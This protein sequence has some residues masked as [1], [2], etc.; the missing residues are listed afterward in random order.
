MNPNNPNPQ[1]ASGGQSSAHPAAEALPILAAPATGKEKTTIR[2]ELIPVA[3]WRINDLRFDFGSSF[4]LPDSK[5]EFVELDALRKDNPGC[6]LTIFG[7]ADPVSSDSF[8]KRLSDHRAESIFGILAHEPARWEKLYKAAGAGEG[9]GVAAIQHMLTAI[10]ENPGPVT[11]TMNPSTKAAV[12]SFQKKQDGLTPDGDPG[13]KTREKLFDAYMTFLWPTP[14]TSEDFL[15]RRADSGGKGDMQG[16]SEFNPA[17]VFSKTEEAELNKAENKSKRN[18]ENGANRRV[19]VLLFRKDSVVPAAKWPC[20]RAGEGTEGC[21]K[22]FWSDGDKRRG[23]QEKRR[24]FKDTRDTFACR[25]YHRLVDSSPCEGID[26]TDPLVQLVLEKVDDHFC[27]NQEKLDIV[28]SV[29]NLAGKPVTLTITSPHAPANPIFQRELTAAEKTNGQHTIQ[30]DG[31]ATAEAEGLKDRFVHPLLSPFTVTLTHNEANKGSLPFKVLYHSVELKQGPWTPDEADPPE[32]EAKKFA[33]VKLNELGYYGGPVEKDTDDYL[34]KAIIRYKANHVKF[35]KV[36]IGDYDDTITPE[37]IAALK[38]KEADRKLKPFEAISDPAKKTVLPVEALTYERITATTDEF[39]KTRPQFDK[40]RL[41]R[42]LVP[43]EATIFLRKKDDSKCLEPEAVGPARITWRFTDANEDTS[44]QFDNKA[45]EPSR[46]KTFIDKSLKA[47]NGTA[48]G[49]GDNCPEDVGGI[50]TDADAFKTPFLLGDHYAPHEVKED[51][52]AKGVFS[53]AAVD[54]AKF[55]K[56]VGKAGVMLRP[57]FISG[58]DYQ[59]SAELD[60]TGLANKAELETFHGIK[61]E[62]TKIQAKTG[63]FTVRRFNRVAV[64]AEWPGRNSPLAKAAKVHL[65]YEWDKIALEFDKT[66][67]DVDVKG[68][69]SKAMSAIIT[70]DEYKELVAAN[71]PHTDKSK[72]ALNDGRMVGV[73]IPTQGNLDADTYKMILDA[74]VNA[75]FYRLIRAPLG[76]LLSKKVRATDASGF[77]VVNFLTHA[78][79]DIKTDPGNGKNGVTAANKDFVNWTGSIGLADSVIL[80]D[81]K[82]PDKVYYVIS[83]E[84]GH[85]FYLLHWENTG[86]NNLKNHDQSDKNCSMSY[87]TNGGPAHQAQGVYTPHFCGKC[88][89]ALRGWDVTSPNLGEKSKSKGADAAPPGTKGTLIVEVTTPLGDPVAGAEVQLAGGAKDKTDKNGKASFPSIDAKSWDVSASKKGAGPVPGAGGLVFGDSAKRA[90]IVLADQ[91]NHTKLELVTVQ[92]IAVNDTPENAAEPKRVYK[93]SRASTSVD[94]ELTAKV[95]APISGGS[96][97]IKHAKVSVEWTFTALADNCPKAKGG[98]DDTDIHFVDVAGF[99]ATGDKKTKAITVTNDDGEAKITF[100]MSV[101]AGD[102][103]TV[104]AKVL[105]GT[106]EVVK[107]DSRQFE[108]W[109]LLNYKGLYMMETGANKGMDVDT[110]CTV[111]NIQPAYTPCFTEYRKGAVTKIPYQEFLSPMV[112]PTAAQRPAASAVRIKSDGADTRKVTIHGLKA[113]ADGSTSAA[114]EEI[115]LNGTAAVTGATVWQK[116]DKATAVKDTARTVSVEEATGTNRAIGTIAA[117][118]ATGT[119]SFV[120]DTDAAVTVKAQAWYQA[121]EDK[122]TTDLNSFSTG[123]AG[124][125]FIGA[126][127]VHPKVDGRNV[128]TTFYAGYPSVTIAVYGGTNLHPDEEWYDNP[129]VNVGTK[130]FICHNAVGISYQKVV[131]RHEIGH[132]ADAEDYGVAPADT[133]HCPTT[134]CLMYYAATGSSFCTTEPEHSERRT[135]GW[136]R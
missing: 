122:M 134:T 54:K 3:C 114:T 6:P 57:S 5:P 123:G 25:F 112:N 15:A 117:N 26:L 136:K 102:M 91:A 47:H 73:S 98:Q 133:A 101:V 53:I 35:R 23:N 33:A 78:P 43:V 80:A 9:W 58:D 128:K 29:K 7:H 45:G 107:A 12:E 1:A 69:A 83:H 39:G 103:Y 11:G 13:P 18:E 77:I 132:A 4:V 87:S 55:P 99:A 100:L 70:N 129:G 88:N 16:C 110:I 109:R 34:K 68:L 71:T 125:Q 76:E 62:K 63:V 75:N 105:D 124:Y 131:A 72:I 113:E 95:S 48:A 121:N 120:F 8:N 79:V 31:K 127:W 130:S 65:D 49:V 24:E 22:R 40:S 84:M 51:A 116:V 2:M 119:F 28:Y 97:A 44:G 37:L 46:T 20:P 42:P 56:R 27:P 115:T 106:T 64:S 74:F 32:A 126:A 82:D 60:F 19:M 17:L 38:N 104:H 118:A 59:Y 14:L 41:N 66:F 86:E 61:D 90:V 21:R 93:P 36:F 67:N 111:A 108:V 94:H 50:R 30:W 10:G 81:M 85:N 92:S 52:A 89:L 135:R 96:G